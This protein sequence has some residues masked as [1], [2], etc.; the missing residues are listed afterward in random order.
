MLAYS[1]M[2]CTFHTLHQN[3]PF[4][5]VFPFMCF[6]QYLQFFL[7]LKF[8]IFPPWIH[9]NNK[10]LVLH[11]FKGENFKSRK[12]QGKLPFSHHSFYRTYYFG[13]RHDII[14]CTTFKNV[15]LKRPEIWDI[16]VN[17]HYSITMH[18]NVRGILIIVIKDL[19]FIVLY[20]E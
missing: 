13:K 20:L 3:I 6:K 5:V 11:V 16:L 1:F 15:I 2:M 19:S 18:R 7:D 4:Y 9:E 17:S 10:I 8:D 14:K 12:N